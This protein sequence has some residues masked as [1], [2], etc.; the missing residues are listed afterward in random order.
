MIESFLGL[1]IASF[2]SMALLITV[3]LNNKTIRNAAR[4]SLSNKE[5]EIIMNAG[6][7]KKDIEVLEIDIKNIT[8]K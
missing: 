7:S 6:Y 1:L 3:G 8:L 4:Y 2:A 5:K